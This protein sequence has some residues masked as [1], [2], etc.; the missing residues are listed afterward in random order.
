MTHHKKMTEVEETEVIDQ[1]NE[2]GGISFKFSGTVLHFDIKAGKSLYP[3]EFGA[4]NTGLEL[5][6]Y[7]EATTGLPVK[8]QKI[9]FKGFY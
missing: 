4:D 5:K 8:N 9:L 7:I 2:A 3:V 1:E 6:Q